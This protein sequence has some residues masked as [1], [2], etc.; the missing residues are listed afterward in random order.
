VNV[1]NCAGDHSTIIVISKAWPLTR[2]ARYKFCV[3]E[4]ATVRTPVDTGMRASSRRL[5]ADMNRCELRPEVKPLVEA[6]PGRISGTTPGWR[7]G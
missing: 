4:F 6:R 1:D 5:R 7:G 3:S 2:T